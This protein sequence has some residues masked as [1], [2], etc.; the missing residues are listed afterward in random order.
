MLGFGLLSVAIATGLMASVDRPV[1]P[2]SPAL[3]ALLSKGPHPE[4]LFVSVALLS[5]GK[6]VAQGLQVSAALLSIQ[7]GDGQ[8]GC[9]EPMLES[10][11]MVR[12]TPD[13]ALLPGDVLRLRAD[14]Q[15]TN[16][17]PHEETAPWAASFWNKPTALLA[18]TDAEQVVHLSEEA[19]REC[20]PSR[21][22]R[23]RWLVRRPLEQLRQ[24]LRTKVLSISSPA[25]SQAVLVAL[26]LGWR[27]Q[28]IEAD[29]RRFQEGRPTVTDEFSA[30]GI[31]HILSVSGLHLAIVGWLLYR[32]ASKALSRSAWLAQR[33]AVHRFAAALTLPLM[34]GYAELTGAEL[35]TIRA[36]CVLGLWLVAMLLGRRTTLAQ[37][38]ALSVFVLGAPVP[39]GGALRLC[40]PSWL[41]SMAA[42]LGMTYLRPLQAQTY[43]IIRLQIPQAFRRLLSWLLQL[44]DATLGATIATAPLCALLFGKFGAM[45]LLANLVLVPIGELAVLPLGLVGLFLG[46]V[47][48]WLGT[49]PLKLALSA[50]TV[51]LRLTAL[52]AKAG[53]VWTVPSPPIAWMLLFALGL[54]VWARQ[55]PRGA[56]VSALA[57]LLYLIDWQR[58]K[59]ELRLTALA[60]GQGDSLVVE[61]PTHQVMVIDAGPA[62]GDGFDAGHS[63]V[64]PYLR[65]RGVSRIDWLVMTHA[66]PD[67]SGGLSSLLREFS[68]G[69]LWIEPLPGRS[70]D[71]PTNQLRRELQ[72]AEATLASLKHLAEKTKALVVRAHPLAVGGVSVEPLSSPHGV[73]VPLGRSLNDASIVLRLRYAGRTLLL[74]GDI[75]ASR[76]AE[77]LESGELSTVDVLKAPHHCSRTSSTDAFV[78]ATRPRLVICSVGKN[79]RFGFPHAPVMDRYRAISATI[80]RTDSRGSFTVSASTTGT[81]SVHSAYEPRFFF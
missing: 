20:P 11:L 8:G 18:R 30:A 24:R 5:A 73:A 6:P 23:L 29:Q 75:E 72:A 51:L 38:L 31:S 66:H 74:T 1:P 40:D 77:L 63:T 62:S 35:P 43:W 4:P 33:F 50:T 58:P 76:E 42:T 67:H 46:H 19:Q 3:D 52:F 78:A 79:N 12:G 47:C 14:L 53:L 36:A 54:V 81:I 59:S 64:A 48:G 27:G 44:S 71:M 80:L 41:L 37:G 25:E 39:A 56:V 21:D 34:L 60:V 2:K 10:T 55:R 28:L 15:R 65:R 49:L 68:V 70:D 16:A 69:E 57:V 45:G 22:L 26:T 61:F 13:F 17:E 7:R 9:L 32:I